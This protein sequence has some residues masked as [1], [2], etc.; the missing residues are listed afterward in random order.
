[1]TTTVEHAELFVHP[2]VYDVPGTNMAPEYICSFRGRHVDHKDKLDKMW[3]FYD[4]TNNEDF[5]VCER[6]QVGVTARAYQGGRM[7][8]RFEETIHRFQNMVADYMT[9]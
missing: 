4:Q 8:F 5:A 7:T 3:A 6:V 9:R 1:P 2:S